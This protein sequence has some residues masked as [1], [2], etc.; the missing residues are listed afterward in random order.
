MWW[1]VTNPP[2]CDILIKWERLRKS[3]ADHVWI[4]PCSQS[5]GSWTT[6]TISIVYRY[7]K[8]RKK[9]L[10]PNKKATPRSKTCAHP[11]KIMLFIRW[12]IEGVLYYELIP[13]GVTITADIYCQQLKRLADAIQE[14]D[15]QDCV[16][17]CNA[18][19]TPA[20]T[21]P[22]WQKHYKDVGRSF[23]THLIYL[24]LRPQILTFSALCRTT[25]KKLPLRMKMCTEHG[26]TT[27]IQNH[28]ISTGADSK[29]YTN[30]VR[31]L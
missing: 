18:N 15:Q 7:I 14:K 1:T 26:L 25:F 3:A 29:K 13:R 24:I 19:I 17:W 31:L 30:V 11:Q 20:R 5:F 10:S 23:R 27:S 6:S 8:K 21:L 12:N 4:C 2:S 22:T 28:V 9:W 16:K